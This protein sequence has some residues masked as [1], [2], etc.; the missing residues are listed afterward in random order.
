M[1]PQGQRRRDSRLLHREGIMGT[2]GVDD[3]MG[4]FGDLPN[5]PGKRVP[6]NR[7]NSTRLIDS[8]LGDRYNGAK[9]KEYIIN[10]KKETFYTIGEVCKALGKRPVTLR[11]WESKGWIPKSSFRTPPPSGVQI[12]EKATKGRRLYTQQQLDTLIDGVALFNI[13]DRHR[14]DWE[15]FKQ[16]IQENWKR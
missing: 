14:G 6:K 3:F 8:G 2:E 9:G 16:Y 5:F 4:L 1:E 15:A 7:P 10:G 12:P 13:A 11:M